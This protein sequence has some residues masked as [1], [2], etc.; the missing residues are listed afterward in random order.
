MSYR[1]CLCRTDKW[2][3]KM[4]AVR[5]IRRPWSQLKTHKPWQT[6]KPLL[7]PPKLFIN[8]L[9]VL[10]PAAQ[11]VAICAVGFIS[12]LACFDSI[13]IGFRRALLIPRPQLDGGPGLS[14]AVLS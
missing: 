11:T 10:A 4:G 6:A 2:P 5:Q 3:V 9:F 12:V 7:R 13:R 1:N 8:F 14:H